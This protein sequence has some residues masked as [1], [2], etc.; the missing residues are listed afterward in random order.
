VPSHSVVT[1]LHTQLVVLM[2]LAALVE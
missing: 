2:D 1:Q